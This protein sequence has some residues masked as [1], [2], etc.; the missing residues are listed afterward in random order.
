M[1]VDDYIDG[2]FDDIDEDE[3]P[4]NVEE[5]LST[6]MFSK[7]STKYSHANTDSNGMFRCLIN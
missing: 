6:I 4:E 5:M 1:Q 7:L 3:S 2:Q